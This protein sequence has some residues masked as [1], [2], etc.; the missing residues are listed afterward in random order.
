MEGFRV[1]CEKCG[2]EVVLEDKFNSIERDKSDD[3]ELYALRGGTICI[4][5]SCGNEIHG[6]EIY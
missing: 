6:D 5:C 2:K 1:I 3:I 4:D